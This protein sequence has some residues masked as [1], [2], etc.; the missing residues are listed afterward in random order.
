MSLL[1]AA[2]EATLP[3]FDV[4]GHGLCAHEAYRDACRLLFSASSICIVRLD[5]ANM[6]HEPH[7]P[8]RRRPA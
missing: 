6:E 2:L 7:A 3:L 4:P 1:R 5:L 8:K